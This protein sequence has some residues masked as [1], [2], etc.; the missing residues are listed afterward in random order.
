MK[1]IHTSDWHIGQTLY[2]F[3]R[4]DEHKFFFKQLKDI[5]LE[6][7]PDVLIVSGD[8]FLK[9]Y[10]QRLMSQ[11]SAT[12]ISTETVRRATFLMTLLKYRSLSG[13]KTR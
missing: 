5:I 13:E 9:S 11:W 8:I 7:N 10:G 6:E 3:S 1:V 12:W 2:Q 4:D